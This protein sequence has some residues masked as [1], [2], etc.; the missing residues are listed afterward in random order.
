MVDTWQKS[1]CNSWFTCKI[2]STCKSG[3]ITKSWFICKPWFMKLHWL[4]TIKVWIIL[5]QFP[6]L[7]I[8]VARTTLTFSCF[9]FGRCTTFCGHQSKWSVVLMAKIPLWTSES[10]LVLCWL[11]AQFLSTFAT[12]SNCHL[13]LSHVRWTTVFTTVSAC[14]CV[15][16]FCD[17]FEEI[18]L[19]TTASVFNFCGR[20]SFVCFLSLTSLWWRM[21]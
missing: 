17:L 12:D 7:L 21:T 3:F 1:S 19:P 15:C 13:Q 5:G 9:C 2:I 18:P 20:L 10:I 8:V 11:C 4:I 6:H 16:L 14:V